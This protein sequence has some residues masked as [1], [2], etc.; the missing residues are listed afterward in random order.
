[1]LEVTRTETKAVGT[2]IVKAGC[3]KMPKAVVFKAGL[4]IVE[5]VRL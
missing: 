3:L 1:M 5:V 2:F 4:P